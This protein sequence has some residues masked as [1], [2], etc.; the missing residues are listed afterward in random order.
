MPEKNKAKQE[1]YK[2]DLWGFVGKQL[3]FHLWIHSLS[4][5]LEYSL[6][7][8]AKGTYSEI[9]YPRPEELHHEPKIKSLLCSFCSKIKTADLLL[10]KAQNKKSI[11][12][13]CC[14]SKHFLSPPSPPKNTNYLWCK[15]QCLYRVS[16]RQ[17]GE[18][19]L[20]KDGKVNEWVGGL[21]CL[22]MGKIK[23]QRAHVHLCLYEMCIHLGFRHK[24]F[25]YTFPTFSLRAKRILP[26]A[27]R[28]ICGLQVYHP[29]FLQV[30]TPGD[31]PRSLSGAQVLDR[32]YRDAWAP[33]ET[34]K[35]T[36][37]GTK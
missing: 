34:E 4:L 32:K 12:R 30:S 10:F 29:E 20:F 8:W 26:V 13:S 19:H 14:L 17:R 28:F 1:W 25:L 24:K 16:Q 22:F 23:C 3:S 18:L 31:Q 9:I 37:V 15:T 36:V 27:Q 2:T 33:R 5:T 11:R 7:F 6:E 35:C 21:T